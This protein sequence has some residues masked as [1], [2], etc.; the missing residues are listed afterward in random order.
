MEPA[1]KRA[2]GGHLGGQPQGL[3]C[4]HAVRLIGPFRRVE[5]RCSKTQAFNRKRPLTTQNHLVPQLLN[6]ELETRS[7]RPAPSSTAQLSQALLWFIAIEGCGGDICLGQSQ[8]QAG[9]AGCPNLRVGTAPIWRVGGAE[10]LSLKRPP[11]LGL[12]GKSRLAPE[13]HSPIALLCTA[14]PTSLP[15]D[16]DWVCLQG[17]PAQLLLLCLTVQLGRKNARARK[18]EG[19]RAG[20]RGKQRTHRSQVRPGFVGRAVGRG[21]A[22]ETG[23]SAPTHPSPPRPEA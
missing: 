14:A 12:E 19:Y 22:A 8:V 23:T 1:Q 11:S 3:G 13:I 2:G 5:S 20:V 15:A 18:R 4:E 21:A 16:S 7:L 6:Q 17:L 9:T 10:G